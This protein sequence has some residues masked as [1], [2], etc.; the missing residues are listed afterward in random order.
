[1]V[2]F[3][4]L[5]PLYTSA[6]ANYCKDKSFSIDLALDHSYQYQ[7]RQGR[8]GRLASHGFDKYHPNFC[9]LPVKYHDCR[10]RRWHCS[11]MGF[12]KIDSRCFDNLGKRNRNNCSATLRKELFDYLHHH[13]RMLLLRG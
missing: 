1:M 8:L 9:T 2:F 11:D 13:R 3:L 6:Y 10:R 12:S 4:G 7:G 5:S